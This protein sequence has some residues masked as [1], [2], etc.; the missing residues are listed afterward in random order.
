MM[1][2]NEKLH[3]FTVK[4]KHSLS[5]IGAT[6][7]VL[8]HEK[9][10]A[11]LIYMDRADENKTFSI[12]FKTLPTDSTGV[13]HIIE[14][15]VLC[16]SEK[17]KL[18]DPFVELLSGS[19]NTFLNAMTFKD[20]TMYPVAST[21]E[22]EFLNLA[23]VYLDAVFNPLAVKDKK[24]FMQEG[25]HYEIGEGGE[26]SYKGVVFN[27]MKG[28]YS[29]PE[30][31]AERHIHSMLFGGTCYEHDSGGDPEQITDLTFEE[32]R[33]AHALYYHPSNSVIF[34]DGEMNIDP[35]LSLIEKYLLPYDKISVTGEKF[36]FKEALPKKEYREVEYEI[37]E[38]EDEK[39]KTR[40]D[41]AHL[42]FRFDE[43]KNIFGTAILSSALMSSNES[44]IKK[45]ILSSHLCEDMLIDIGEGIYQNYFA[46]EFVNVKDGKEEELKKLFY[47][48]VAAVA[49]NGINKS[50]LVAAINSLEFTLRERD[51][52]RYPLGI[53]YAMNVLESFLYSDD[54]LSGLTFE[55]EIAF[56]R[57]NTE[58]GF[59]E[60]LLRKI[61][62]E[63]PSAVALVLRP[64]KKLGEKNVLRE[65]E[66]LLEKK[67]EMT[68][69]ELFEIEKE[70]E[71]LLAWQSADESE[72]AKAAIPRLK[73]S[74][75]PKEVKII[76]TKASEVGE[77]RL[78]IHDIVTNGICYTELYFDVSDISER[79][80]F[81]SALLSLF[82]GNLATEKYSASELVRTL[83][84]EI[85]SISAALKTSTKVSGETKC[86]FKV[87]LSSL[88]SKRERAAELL[89]EVLLRTRFDERDSMESIVKQAYIA[90][91][92]SFAAAGHR[93]ARSRIS[94]M[95]YPEA[96]ALEYYSGYEAHKS[97]KELSRSFEAAYERLCA[98]LAAFINKY[99][100]RERLTVAVSDNSADSSA[101][102]FGRIIAD[103]FPDSGDKSVPVC[104][105]SPLPKRNEGIKIA[106]KISFS[107][108]GAN[109]ALKRIGEL[110][111]LT[112]VSNLVSYDYLWSEIRV[113]GGAYGTGMSAQRTGL[114]SF[115]SYRDPT[116]IRTVNAIKKAPD[117]LCSAA[118]GGASIDKYIIGAIGEASPYMTPRAMADVATLRYLNGLTDKM[119]EEIRGEILCVTREKI[120]DISSRLSSAMED[121]VF[122]VIGPKEKLDGENV[123]IILDI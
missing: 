1:N 102:N 92:E 52:G 85:G 54:A 82:L 34:L 77:S 25:W 119:R 23:D 93:A 118:D 37:S 122:C 35:I 26:L 12:A 61:F 101:E 68:E 31:V 28:D 99:L 96:A 80:I 117:F 65:R 50:D 11:R 46:V 20:K 89:K 75:I 123:D 69:K 16:G 17:Y 110:G 40:L 13:F 48:T 49:D 66:R 36:D 88:S 9:S 120:K 67:A 74:D 86:Y 121:S 21:N 41:I 83:K 76:P 45:A 5:A 27:E 106:A 58:S 112:V 62:I 70:N 116:P 71:E 114:V 78:L 64:S 30:S 57:E 51:F 4:E 109:L 22:K 59:F 63:N 53:I 94:A 18:K 111:S 60:E 24:A 14:H 7:Y 10:G 98:E 55:E 108:L 44:E 115:Y 32:F 87:F 113:K 105:I 95:L 42:T 29:S 2:K 90:S 81:I 79:E 6:L 104:K 91:E 72:A 8:A 47:D 107:A 33:A 3:G 56:L 43:R 84:S 73:V 103:I 100:V 39:D 15:S 38:S 19:L 97:Y